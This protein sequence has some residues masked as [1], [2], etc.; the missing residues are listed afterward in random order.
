[1]LD[2]R[3]GEGVTAI[4]IV[5][6]GSST[7]KIRLLGSDDSV[8]GSWDAMPERLPAV[9][10]VAHRVVHG[11]AIFSDAVVIDAEVERQI[12]DLSAL[13]PLHQPKALEALAAVRERLP[14][15]RQVACFDTAFHTTIPAAAATYALPRRWN[16]TYGLKKFGFHGLSHAWANRQVQ[17]IAPKARRVVSCH[18]GGGASLAAVV[19]GVSVDT[20]M[21]FTPVAGLV[22]GTR[23]GDVDPGLLMWLLDREPDLSSALESESGLLGLAG[24]S[25]M[26]ELLGLSELAG[27]PGSDARL[28]LDVYL[29]RL[30]QGIASMAASMGGIDAC[31]FT[32]GVGEN[33]P[34][35]RSRAIAGLA[36]LGLSAD[37]AA[38]AA[39]ATDA[40]I[41]APDAV[42][43]TIV[44]AAREDLEMARQ[45]RR[46]AG[47][48]ARDERPIAG[49]ESSL[50][51]AGS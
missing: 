7:L 44:V 36:F 15:A 51:G 5:N 4:L 43:R 20:T 30:R 21:G 23:S 12:R 14:A 50:A 6:A 25:D 39:V 8:L 37:E 10:L 35:I 49:G 40:D 31:V 22:M 1:V 42:A 27:E 18:L 28:A 48:S 45:A 19:D 47:P 38:N 9:D 29:H 2:E 13:A 34:L 32:G 46:V 41:S 11:G 26:R 24:T 17:L 3:Q 16:Q 33:A